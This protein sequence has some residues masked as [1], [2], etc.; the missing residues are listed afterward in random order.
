MSKPMFRAPAGL[1]AKKPP[2]GK[3]CTQ[4]GLCCMATLC[5]LAQHV[6]HR[7]AALG[8][9]PALRKIDD[10]N[11]VCGFATEP[12]VPQH[13]REAAAVIIGADTGCDARFNGE[14]SDQAFYNALDRRD[15]EKADEIRKAKTLWAM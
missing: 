14:P 10:S 13:L 7:P 15:V 8:P 3:P 11:Y 9:C 12:Q 2:H 5:G 4:C 6:F 1:L